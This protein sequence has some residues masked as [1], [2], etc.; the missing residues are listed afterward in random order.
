M[1]SMWFFKQSTIW[2]L[3]T[4]WTVNFYENLYNFNK[5]SRNKELQVYI[6]CEKKQSP[7]KSKLVIFGQ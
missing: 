6:V 3:G 2:N 4:D 1:K 5:I 7:M